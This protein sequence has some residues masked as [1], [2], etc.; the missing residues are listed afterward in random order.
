MRTLIYVPIIHT[1]PDLGSLA[2]EVE[3]KA[4][5]FLGERWSK[6]KRT[7]EKYWQE[8]HRYFSKKKFKGV[9]IFQDGLPVG[10]EKGKSLVNKLAKTGS[11]N[12]K[13]L[14]NLIDQGATLLKT[15]EPTLLKKEYQLTKNLITKK[16]LLLAIFAF[17]NYK[18]TKDSLL[19]ARDEYIANQINQNLG[20][21]ETGICFLGTYHEVLPKL[22][23]DIKIVLL[24]NPDKVKKYY[25]LLSSG[26]KAGKVNGLTR[27][28]I[29]PVKT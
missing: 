6:H 7:V 27:Y 24:K 22:A 25:Q 14:K 1:D 26:E 5:R 8:I 21:G 2:S 4:L 23:E 12:Y 3:K 10:G 28:L 20:K 18:F 19:K 13:L 17:L 15:E 9:K 16:N 29:E 11:P